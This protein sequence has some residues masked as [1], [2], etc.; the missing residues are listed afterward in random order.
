MAEE[1]L[2]GG[3]KR[4][5]AWVF[6]TPCTTVPLADG[7]E[8]SEEY[9]Q[10]L[11]VSYAD[12]PVPGFNPTAKLLAAELSAEK[13]ADFVAE[14]FDKWLEGN[15]EAK[16]KWVLYAASSHGGHRIIPALHHQIQEWPQHARGAM[17]AEAVKA[18]ALNGNAEALLLVDNISR[19]FKFRQVKT[20]ASEALSYAAEQMGISKAELED[21]IVPS[22]GFGE[23][24]SR[25]F[26]YGTRTFTVYLTPALELEVFDADNKRLKN[27]PAPGK[28]D[29]EAKASEAYTEFKQLKKQLKTVVTNQKLRLEQALTAERLWKTDQWEAL[30]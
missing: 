12:M 30:L 3:K 5:I 21:R 25:T 20:A 27:L 13:L 11:L 28:R 8:A 9:L 16:K 1:I 14:L 2:K 26:D 18:L 10:A 6:E 17:A 7:K 22:L 24:L 19:K 23:D 15:A 29:D 4:K